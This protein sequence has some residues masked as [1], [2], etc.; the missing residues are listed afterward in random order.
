MA[1]YRSALPQLTGD[2]FLTDGGIETTLVFHDGLDLPY[3]A[4]FDLLKHEDGRQALLRYFRSHASI[5]SEYG[6]G[7]VLESATWRASA[8][9]GEKLG[10]SKEALA[11]VNRQAIAM[12]EEVRAEYAG[13]DTRM[14]ISG[15]VG[16]RGD[17]YDPTHVMGEGEAQAYHAE[18]IRT[19]AATA[20]DMVTAITMTNIPEAIGVTRAA[21]A[22]GMPAVISFTVETDGTL[23]TGD[24]L[25]KA[26]ERVDMATQQG[27]AYYMINCAHPTHFEGALAAGE[28]WVERLG[29]LRANASTGC[30]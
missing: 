22:A 2:L 30:S 5:A 24:S 17:G 28:P 10:Y 20:A 1:R 6:V 8:D 13:K 4:A 12:L 27:P 14:V 18:Q 16:P 19:F 21:Q 29:G 26:I 15:C 23:P 3:F 9:W 25:K 11:D 7:F